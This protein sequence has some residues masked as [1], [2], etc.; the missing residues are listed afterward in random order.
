[1]TKNMDTISLYTYDTKSKLVASYGIIASTTYF[2]NTRKSSQT[3]L[4]QPTGSVRAK[5][6]VSQ[7]ATVD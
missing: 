1:M 4:P 6:A 7:S 3:K 2:R 5:A